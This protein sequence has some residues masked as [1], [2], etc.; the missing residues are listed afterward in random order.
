MG[1][2]ATTITATSPA[3]RAKVYNYLVSPIGPIMRV[4][5]G[6][7]I[8]TLRFRGRLARKDGWARDHDVIVTNSEAKPNLITEVE[9]AL[10]SGK[11]RLLVNFERVIA[12]P[13]ESVRYMQT[14]AHV[15]DIVIQK[16]DDRQL[17]LFQV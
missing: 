3:V 9:A 12:G 13:D 16:Q 8:E 14:L 6:A 2:S 10:K 4:R 17:A 5:V 15:E 7:G 1:R 11:V